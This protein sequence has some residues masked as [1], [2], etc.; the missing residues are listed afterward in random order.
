MQRPYFASREDY[1]TRFTNV[2]YWR[3][4][5]TS[6]CQRHHLT[7]YQQ[8]RAGKA[9]T[10]PVFIVNERYAVKLFAELFDGEE[11]FRKELDIY[12]LCAY[13]PALP[14]PKLITYGSV[15]DEDDS[16]RWPYTISTVIPGVSIGSV[17]P[18]I[19][20]EDKLDVATAAGSFLHT[21]HRLPLE[22]S[23]FFER[24]WEPFRVVLDYQRIHC[25]EHHRQWN[26]LPPHLIARLD[27][28]LPPIESLFDPQT[29]PYLL[30]TDLFDDHVL[31]F[32]EHGRWHTNGFIDFGDALAGDRLYELIALHIGLFHGDKRLLRA[33][34]QTC[35]L[36]DI[37]EDQFVL[38]T[39]S[40]ALLRQF[41]VFQPF[42]E[43]H[44]EALTSTTLE[45]LALCMWGGIT[46][47]A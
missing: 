24:S 21:F 33:F 6:V 43:D 16:Y 19:S 35:K 12:R 10:H 34:V 17:L 40:F 2:D 23:S 13:A 38:K 30:H 15:F 36:A 26:A 20:F 18:E 1:A 14:V 4:Y 31:G 22:H 42:F 8:I 41:N 45:E 37:S 27:D 47:P 3:P 9:G 44:P 28:Y 5:I 7:P 39:M 25:I 46:D 29:I 32:L 11:S